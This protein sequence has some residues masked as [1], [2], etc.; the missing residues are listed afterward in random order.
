MRFKKK[1][2]Q[3]RLR[4]HSYLFTDE[5]FTWL[6]NVYPYFPNPVLVLLVFEQ[7]GVKMTS[8]ALEN[9]AYRNHWFKDKENISQVRRENANSTNELYYDSTA[10]GSNYAV[11]DQ[12]FLWVICRELERHG[13]SVRPVLIGKPMAHSEKHLLINRGF[14]GQAR[15]VPY[16]NEQNNESLLISIQT[17]GVYNGHKD[18]RLEKTRETDESRLEERTDFSDAFDTLYIGCERFPQQSSVLPTTSDF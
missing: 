17:A 8:K 10:L 9:M 1:C 7:T 11:N 4:K 6:E 16:F 12:D 2:N 3:K 5:Q 13:W 14:A 18:K 15:L